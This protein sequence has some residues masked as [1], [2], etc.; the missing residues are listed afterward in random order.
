MLEAVTLTQIIGYD[1]KPFDFTDDICFEGY[2]LKNDGFGVRSNNRFNNFS[3]LSSLLIL[4]YQ[5]LFSCI[6]YDNSLI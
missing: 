6:K 1:S 3:R 4:K 2:E 5:I